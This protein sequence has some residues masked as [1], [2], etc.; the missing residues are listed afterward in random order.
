MFIKGN[1]ENAV[2]DG[3]PKTNNAVEGWHR[4]FNSL[5]GQTNPTI[6]A[7]IKTI[8]KEESYTKLVINQIES[9]HTVSHQS[10]TYRQTADRIRKLVIQ[11]NGND[12]I[13]YLRRLANNVNLNV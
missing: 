12:K 8:Q 5:L 9:G 10:Q 11:Y 1:C 13:G 2:K 4:R 7:F 3:I 6:W